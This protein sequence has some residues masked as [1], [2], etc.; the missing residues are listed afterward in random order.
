[1]TSPV[2]IATEPNDAHPKLRP[3]IVEFPHRGYCSYPA[4]LR[5]VLSAAANNDKKIKYPALRLSHSA[6]VF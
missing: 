1:M 4:V 5:A 6:F 2:S 3:I